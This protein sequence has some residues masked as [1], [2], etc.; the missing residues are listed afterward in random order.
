MFWL[1]GGCKAVPAPPSI[2]AQGRLKGGSGA[3]GEGA[4]GELHGCA[5]GPFYLDPREAQGRLKGCCK[6]G[7]LR[8]SSFRLKGG[9]GHA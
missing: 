5:C 7:C 3:G 4:Q 2:W 8:P 1:K 9:S 6:A